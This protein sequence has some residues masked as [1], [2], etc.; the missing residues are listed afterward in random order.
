[1]K[2]VLVIDD[3]VDV[4]E[5]LSLYLDMMGFAVET[6]MEGR[7]ALDMIKNK[8]YNY[9]FCDLK[10]PDMKGEEVLREIEKMDESLV[11]RFIFVTGAVISAELESFFSARYVKILRKPFTFK[12]I[13][14]VIV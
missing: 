4:V 5:V 9:I 1:M 3:D 12:D 8:E 2:K 11:R 6:A 7:K 10:M 13:E 14:S